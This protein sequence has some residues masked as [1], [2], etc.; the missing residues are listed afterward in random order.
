[1]CP[2]A[3]AVEMLKRPDGG[4]PGRHRHAIGSVDD[5]ANSMSCTTIAGRSLVGPSPF[6]RWPFPSHSLLAPRPLTLDTPRSGDF[7]L[8]ENLAAT[9]LDEYFE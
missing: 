4:G 1:M 8:L 5:G 3:S 6:V 7:E 9:K 2:D